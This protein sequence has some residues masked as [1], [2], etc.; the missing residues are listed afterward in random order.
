MRYIASIANILILVFIVFLIFENVYS[1]W[2][3][4]AFI[5]WLLFHALKVHLWIVDCRA[6]EGETV[7]LT[8][9]SSGIG[10]LNINHLLRFLKI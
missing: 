10:N 5:L 6:N 3:W 1:T 8:G 7:I 4:L 9:A 2:L